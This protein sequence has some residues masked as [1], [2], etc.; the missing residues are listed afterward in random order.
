MIVRKSITRRE[1]VKK[2]HQ[3]TKT[4]PNEHQ[5]HLTCNWPVAQGCFQA[6][7][8]TD[9]DTQAMLEL[10][11]I[12]NLIKL[13]VKKDTP[14]HRMHEGHREFTR[15]LDLNNDSTGFMSPVHNT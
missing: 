11:A 5:I 8:I 15:I 14:S 13:Y 6:V 1:L 3:I 10:Y 2:I 4:N 7:R 9:D 12:V